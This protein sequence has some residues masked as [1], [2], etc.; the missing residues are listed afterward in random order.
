MRLMR[1]CSRLTSSIGE[2]VPDD[3]S[4]VTFDGEPV[5][6]RANSASRS[7]N[8]IVSSLWQSVESH[9]I[10]VKRE[11]KTFTRSLAEEMSP[12]QTLVGTAPGAICLT[13]TTDKCKAGD[14][15]KIQRQIMVLIVNGAKHL[16]W[17]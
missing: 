2:G 17:K 8:R 14:Y 5:F 9:V 10:Q 7:V 12:N 13:D 6:W 15:A 16:T 3:T 11:S 1:C 4:R